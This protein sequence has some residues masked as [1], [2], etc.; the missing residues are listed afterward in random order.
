MNEKNSVVR[1]L[2]LCNLT[3]LKLISVYLKNNWVNL[4]CAWFPWYELKE[5]MKKKR[6]DRKNKKEC[7]W[8]RIE[9]NRGKKRK[10]E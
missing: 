3:W 10:I 4:Q 9:R 2:N 8:Y 7:V 6:N 5:N 1:V